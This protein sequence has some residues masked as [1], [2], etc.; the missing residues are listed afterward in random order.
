MADKAM[1][2]DDLIGKLN[3]Q[4]REEDDLNFD[5]E[6]PDETGEAEFMV[7][8]K[9]VSNVNSIIAPAL[10]GK[11]PTAQTEL[12]NFMSVL[13]EP[14][15]GNIGIGLAFMAV[16]KGYR[17]VLTM[18]ASMSMER[19]IILKAFG[20]ELILTGPLLGMKG[21]ISF[22]SCIEQFLQCTPP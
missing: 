7:I 8:A 2:V 4:E 12:D 10:I 5:E 11:D 15:S 6:F 19:R 3:L 9:A 20:A 13:I 22:E 16:A 17:L 21:A 14:T 1:G 18:P